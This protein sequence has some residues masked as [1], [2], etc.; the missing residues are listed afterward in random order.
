VLFVKEVGLKP[1]RSVSVD[2][3]PAALLGASLPKRA[4]LVGALSL[5]PVCT[6][7]ASDNPNPLDHRLQMSGLPREITGHELQQLLVE[8]LQ[9]VIDAVWRHPVEGLSPSAPASATVFTN[10]EATYQKMLLVSGRLE[11]RGVRL[12]CALRSREAQ[13]ADSPLLSSHIIHHQVP[14]GFVDLRYPDT[15]KGSPVPDDPLPSDTVEATRSE[16]SSLA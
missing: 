1:K 2:G 9:L 16:Q 15:A 6:S 7:H 3:S 11:M 10:D 5:H 8:Q 12:P 14:I 4:V 13:E